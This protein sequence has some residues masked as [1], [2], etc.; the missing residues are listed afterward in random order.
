MSEVN[1]CELQGSLSVPSITT[2]YEKASQALSQTGDVQFELSSATDIDA[3]GIQLLLAARRH[4]SE[5]QSKF[6]IVGMKDRV[7]SAIESAGAANVFSEQ[8]SEV[9]G[10]S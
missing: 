4:V 6:E 5:S 2:L 3:S 8:T 7:K 1:K 9:E 10:N